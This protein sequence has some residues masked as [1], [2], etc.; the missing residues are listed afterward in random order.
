MDKLVV[1]KAIGGSSVALAIISLV[2]SK[3]SSLASPTSHM[4]VFTKL[5]ESERVES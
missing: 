3:L 4:M 1:F 2:I 5:E